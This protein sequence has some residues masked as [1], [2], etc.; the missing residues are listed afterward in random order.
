MTVMDLVGT[1]GLGVGTQAKYYAHHLAP[2]SSFIS[3]IK[4]P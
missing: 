3:C 2:V 4:Y 1:I